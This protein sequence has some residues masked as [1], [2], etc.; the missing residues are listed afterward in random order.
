MIRKLLIIALLVTTAAFSALADYSHDLQFTNLTLNAN[1]PFAAL[2]NQLNAVVYG[3][4]SN[5]VAVGKQQVY[6]SG[7]FAPGQPW[8][9][10]ANWSA[11]TVVTSGGMVGSNLTAVTSSGNLF[12]AGGDNNWIFTSPNGIAWSTNNFKVFNNNALIGGLAYNG[13]NFVAAGEA[14]EISY[15]NNPPQTTNWIQSTFTNLS[16]AESYRGITRYGANGFVVCGI[17]GLVRLSADAGQ[18][19]QQPLFGN[20]G[21]PDFY[22][23]ATDGTNTFVC[24]GATNATAGNGINGMILASTNSHGTN[25][26]VAFNN[27]AAVTPI[28][29]VAY[30]GSG[31]V[32]VGNSGQIL[33]STN[34]VNWAVVPPAKIPFAHVS[35]ATNL[36]LNGVTFATSGY[37]HDVG[38]IVGANGNVIITAPPPPTNNSLG[39]KWI[40]VGVTNLIQVGTNTALPANTLQVTNAWGTN[41][42]AVD[43]YDAPAGGNQITTGTFITNGMYSFT[44]PFITTNS[45]NYTNTYYAQARDLRTGFVNT[46]RTAMTLTNF[47][48]P[49]AAM[50]TTNIICNGD[51]TTIQANLAGNGPWTVY[52]TDGFTFFT[53]TV[54]SSGIVYANNPF[55]NT[56]NLPSSAFNV[57]NLFLNAA[58]NHYFW[59]WKLTD[60]YFPP[61]DPT[62]LNPTG[63]NWSSD[64]TGT[65][66]ITVNPRP[67]ATLVTSNTICNGDTTSLQ[68][69]LTGIGPWLVYWTDGV[70]NYTQTVSVNGAGPYTN[71]L[72]IR[73]SAFNPTNLFLNA[74]T[75]HYYSVYALS[76]TNCSANSSDITGT[77]LITVN[78]RPTATLVTTNTICNG[79]TT[80]LQA[81]LTGIGPWIVNWTDGVSNYT[82]TVSVNSAGPY[83]DNLTII[84][85]AFNPTNLFLNAATNHYYSVYALSD[86]NCSANS[87]DIAGTDLVKVNPR[88]TATLVTTN[89]ICNGDT[90]VLQANLTGI[91]PWIV[92]WTDGVSNYAQTVSV[93]GAGPYTNYL[94]IINSAFNPTNL[95]LNEATNY[96][97]SVYALSDTNCSANASDINGTNSITVNPRPTV[98]L[99][100]F[101]TT[102]C[103]DGTSFTLTNSLTGLGPWVVYWNDGF[104]QTNTSNGAGPTNLLRTVYP[105][106]SFKANTSSNNI[107][108]VTAVSNADTCLGNQAGDIT[109]T[110]ILT[111]NPRPTS[112]LK[113][114]N[115]TNCDVGASYWLTNVLTGIGPW[116]NVWSLDGQTFQQVVGSVGQPGP[117]TNSLLVFPT[118]SVGADTASNNVYYVSALINGDTCSGNESGDI[119]G[120]NTLTINPRPTAILTALNATNCN[121]GTAFILTNTLHGLGPWF[122][123][124]NDGFKQTNASVGSGPATLTRTVHPT[125]SFAAN[126]VSNNIYY[127]TAVSNIDTCIGNQPG[128]ILGTNILTINPR[129]TSVLNI[130]NTTNCNVGASYWLTNVLTGIGPWTNVWS[131]DGQTFQQV[132][133]SVGQ[134]GPFTNSLLVSPT[135]SVGANTASNNVYYVASLINGDTCSGNESG[136]LVG[137]N[138]L[139]INP[140][141]TATIIQVTNSYYSLVTFDDLPDTISGIYLTNGY[142]GLDWVNFAEGDGIEIGLAFNE[143]SFISAVVSSSNFL[144]NAGG[145][146][147]SIT[148]ATPFNLV[149]VYMTAGQTDGSQATVLGYTN[150]SLAYSNVY[151]LSTN[152]PLFA[153][154]NY[155]NVTEVDFASS[156]G[157]NILMDNLTVKQTGPTEEICNGG[158]AILQ[159]ALTGIKPWS[160]T[161]S[162]SV[163]SNNIT[164]NLITRIVPASEVTN[165]FLNN[166]TNYTFTITSI[167]D[168]NACSGNQP[169]DLVGTASVTVSPRPTAFVSGNTNISVNGTNQ[170]ASTIQA[171]LTGFGPWNVTWSDG[172]TQTWTNASPATRTVTNGLNYFVNSFTNYV[173]QRLRSSG[174][175][176]ASAPLTSTDPGSIP[177]PDGTNLYYTNNMLVG[178]LVV[179]P[180][181]NTNAHKNQLQLYASNHSYGSGFSTRYWNYFTIQTNVITTG[182]TNSI[183]SSNIVYTATNLVDAT[184]CTANSNDLTG[185]ANILLALA[186]TADISTPGSTNICLGEP[187]LVVAIFS[188]TPPWTIRWSD[189]TTNIVQETNNPYSKTVTPTNTGS[190]FN[191]TITNIVDGTNGVST[192]ITGAVA[193][194]VNPI[195]LGV[196]SSNGNQTNCAGNANPPLTVTDG[197]LVSWYDANYNLVACGTNSFTPSATDPGVYTYYAAETN[198][199]GCAGTNV[200]VNLVILSCA[201]PPAITYA[202]TNGVGSI[203]WFGNWSLESTTN[204]LPPVIWTSVITNPTVS[205]YN[206]YWTNGVPPWTN[207]YYFFRLNTN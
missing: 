54:G 11:G 65:D 23:I 174:S 120:T 102:N 105:T 26:Q 151:T 104:K 183:V 7:H 3:G 143:P 162:D 129:P 46:N 32:A 182:A 66:L 64:L 141:P 9:T 149:S 52:W 69:N 70:S 18:I 152:K 185:S 178:T 160:V 154:F 60:S 153:F 171:D 42:V 51:T 111:I 85:S 20:I 181:I 125:N 128:D 155:S 90:T 194:Y 165:V 19:W 127:V 75:N 207:P 157:D 197:A 189:G 67:T 61:D 78:P 41:V 83:T 112:T 50:I 14:P 27:A 48:R 142:A 126:A 89:T 16:F 84:N 17:F 62:V 45:D 5:F 82:Q 37:M 44:P 98:S 140:R 191:Y 163:V 15:T 148:N 175:S 59:V 110:N 118:N 166:T 91:G 122:V 36:N 40:C 88:P 31:Y 202:G 115:T 139:T 4:S 200:Q 25:W 68:A 22:G 203:Q 119:V 34:G 58:T 107:Y 146:P 94:T 28:N 121:D 6:A 150:G 93:N 184:T 176:S 92:N 190:W 205:T 55:T 187:V 192:F 179:A 156:T 158:P 204:L 21:Q 101:S 96:Y 56:L 38:E 74:A 132:V 87:S 133:G 80:V 116:T 170:Y 103:D 57:T 97:Y 199:F 13:G 201:N 114:F 193:V 8:F 63:T 30:T 10:N 29:S 206:W 196:P 124:W 134:A 177:A 71:Y 1:L 100:S 79:D 108:Y 72:T 167:S 144:A 39:N 161:W 130:F 164:T 76:D 95:F 113:N 188:G 186:A 24:V 77:N 106:N 145:L 81:N 33:T 2:T 169:G 198:S 99:L 53:N 131:L 43:W 159:A 35:S 123:Y 137:T 73:N 195:P 138:T 49:T 117:L 47:M 173:Y 136:D 86:T 12:V 180:N 168:A 109:G 135:N 147:A 172:V